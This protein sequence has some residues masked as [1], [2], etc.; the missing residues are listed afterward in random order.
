MD[1]TKLI[2]LKT[3]IETIKLKLKQQIEELVDII[4]GDLPDYTLKTLRRAFIEDTDFAEKHT[5]DELTK[6]KNNVAEFGRTLSEETRNALIND[7][8][9]WWGPEVNPQLSAK[10]LEGNTEVWAKLLQIEKKLL[11]FIEEKGLA[12]ISLSYATPARFID[13]KYPPGMIEKYW[14]HISNLR[15]LEEELHLTNEAA[16]KTRQAE[17]WDSL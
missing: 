17:R 7:I 10:T 2:K 9:I 16:K 13:G 1:E 5:N 12:P 11:A 6:F 15:K 8:E 4:T 3:D 14:A